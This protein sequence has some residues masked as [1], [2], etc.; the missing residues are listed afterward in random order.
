MA[1]ERSTYASNFSADTLGDIACWLRVRAPLPIHNI[2]IYIKKWQKYLLAKKLQLIEK[3]RQKKIKITTN[4]SNMD[5][6]IS[7]SRIC[8]YAYRNIYQIHIYRNKYQIYIYI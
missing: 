1:T 4:Q 7:M 5:Y 6:R 2:E 3:P 8:T